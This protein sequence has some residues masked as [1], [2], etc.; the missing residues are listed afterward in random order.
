M[1]ARLC[2]PKDSRIGRRNLN[3]LEL[4]VRTTDNNLTLTVLKDSST[5]GCELTGDTVVFGQNA[6]GD[7]KSATIMSVY[8]PLAYDR[9]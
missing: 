1:S 7:A 8:D 9:I 3:P 2:A 4:N 6:W 5:S